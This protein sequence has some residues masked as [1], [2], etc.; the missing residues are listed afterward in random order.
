MKTLFSVVAALAALTL[1]ASAHA[2]QF[3]TNGDFTTLTNGV[4]QIDNTTTATGW[5]SGASYNFVMADAN[6]GSPGDYG[7]LKLWT[8]GNGG[9]SSWDGLAA[10]SGNFVAMDGAYRTGPVSQMI[11][12]LTIGKTYTLSYSYAFGQQNG[13]SGDTIQHLTTTLGGDYSSTTPDYS[14]VTHSF[15][16]WTDVT[17]KIKATATSENLSFLAYGN[18]PVPPF[19]LVS[20]VSLTGAVPEPATWGL[21]IVGLGGLGALARR[22]RAT[23]AVAA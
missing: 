17:A 9:A 18:L 15:S 19:A 8:A 13:F 10:H 20:N 2:T 11:T 5:S 16:G 22:R 4:G 23:T 3:V 6:V 7:S 1:G 14:L 12:G 21:M